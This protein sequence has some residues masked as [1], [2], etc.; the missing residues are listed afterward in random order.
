AELLIQLLDLFPS[1]FGFE[2]TSLGTRREL[3]D[4][5]RGGSERDERHP[6][7]DVLDGDASRRQK[8]VRERQCC[9]SRGRQ[10]RAGA[11]RSRGQENDEEKN[12]RGGAGTDCRYTPQCFAR[13]RDNRDRAHVRAE[14][15]NL[16]AREHLF[17]IIG[18]RRSYV[19]SRFFN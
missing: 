10:R 4:D 3:A 7:V 12:W 1:F 16:L 14:A 8:V 9:G 17:S 2:L 13:E 19:C 18:V 11:P 5:D 6:V 15:A